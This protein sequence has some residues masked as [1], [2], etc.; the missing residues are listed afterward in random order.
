MK[1]VV[2]FLLASVFLYNSFAQEV[3]GN[4]TLKVLSFNIRCA[5]CEDSGSINHWSKRKERVFQIIDKYDPEIIGLQEADIGQIRDIANEFKDYKW[6]GK[7]RDDGKEAGE[8]TAVFYKR[9]R[10]LLNNAYTYWLSET[11]S[12]PSKGWDAAFRRTV[13]AALFKDSRTE[14]SFC[15]INTHLDNVGVTAR[16]ESA[17][18]LRK[19]AA[20]YSPDF[21][22]II[23]GDFNCTEDSKAYDI[24]TVGQSKSDSLHPGKDDIPLFNS[25]YLSET[26]HTGGKITFNGF[27]SNTEIEN[28]IDFIFVNNRVKVLSHKIITDLPDGLYPSDH[29]PVIIEIVCK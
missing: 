9:D 17:K 28:P 23:T 21:P 20:E 7:G 16:V 27:G 13:T 11:P 15:I 10:L 8:F 12:V 18:M 6:V 22:V 19:T 14:S 24:L 1:F 2:G 3:T 4:N 26:P 25:Q 29:Y 5:T